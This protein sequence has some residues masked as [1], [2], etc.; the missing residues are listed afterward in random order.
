M[1]F[2]NKHCV[3]Y[4]QNFRDMWGQARIA[5]ANVPLYA[6]S[7]DL[8]NGGFHVKKPDGDAYAYLVDDFRKIL[9]ASIRSVDKSQFVVRA[10]PDIVN[11]FSNVA[12]SLQD[13][14]VFNPPNKYY[15]ALM[16]FVNTLNSGAPK[17]D[18]SMRFGVLVNPEIVHRL[19]ITTDALCVVSTDLDKIECADPINL[20]PGQFF[21]LSEEALCDGALCFSLVP[22]PK[23]ETVLLPADLGLNFM[24]DRA[25]TMFRR[26][27]RLDDLG[28][29]YC[30]TRCFSKM[31]IFVPGVSNM[32]LIGRVRV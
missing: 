2:L 23:Q 28:N 30:V 11:A 18:N 27:A 12:V 26:C 4:S 1:R 5:V 10:E 15:R 13:T 3:K 19:P 6:R 8:S 17:N 24:V 29:D 31:G 7:Y 20:Q 22:S 32:M 16:R 9:N 14:T 21:P 25:T